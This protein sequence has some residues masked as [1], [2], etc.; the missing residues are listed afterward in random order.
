MYIFAFQISV[1]M[2]VILTPSLNRL[3]SISGGSWR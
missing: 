1:A 2:T 3:Y